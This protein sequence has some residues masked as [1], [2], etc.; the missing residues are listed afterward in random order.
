MLRLL[1]SVAVTRQ[2]MCS[3][4]GQLTARHGHSALQA[5]CTDLRRSFEMK[6]SITVFNIN[7]T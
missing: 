1:C 5:Y 2:T 4:T 3:G 6:P 7:S